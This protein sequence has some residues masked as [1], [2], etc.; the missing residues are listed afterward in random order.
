MRPWMMAVFFTGLGFLIGVI[1][2]VVD[3]LILVTK[4]G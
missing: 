2:Y 3:V 4:K 1:I